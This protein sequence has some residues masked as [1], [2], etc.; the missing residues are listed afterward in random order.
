MNQR[1]FFAAVSGD[2]DDDERLLLPFAAVVDK[3]MYVRGASKS[4]I[5][6]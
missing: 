5:E 1:S 2:D 3:S 6:P 4:N